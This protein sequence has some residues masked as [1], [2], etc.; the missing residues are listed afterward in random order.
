MSKKEVVERLNN[1]RRTINR[2]RYLYHVLDQQEISEAALDSLKHELAELE[3]QYPDLVTPDSPT[4]RVGGEP[5][6]KFTK[7]KHPVPQWSFNDAFTPDEMRE[8][9]KRV[10]KAL[11]VDKKPT[12]IAELKIDGFKIVLTYV[13]GLLKTAATR[14]NGQVG[15]DVTA[16]V[17]TIEAIPLKLE[18]EVDVVVEGEIWLSK[19][20]FD[21]INKEQKNKGESLYANPRNVAAGTIRQLDPKVVSSRHLDNFIYDLAQADF[22]LPPTQQAELQLLAELGFK[23]NKYHIFCSTIEEV[24]AFWQEWQVKKDKEAYWIDGVVVKVNEQNYQEELGYTGKAPRFAIAFKFPAEQA[25][26]VVEDIILQVGRQGTITPVARLRPTFLAGST[27]SRATLHNE[28][29]IKRLDVR[30]GDTVILQKA[31]DV[32]PDIVQVMTEMRTGQEKIFCWPKKLEACLPIGAGEKEKSGPI[33]RI[34]GQAAWRCVNK[35][36]FAQLRRKFYHFVSKAAFDIEKL[37]PRVVDTLLENNLVARYDDI[38][39]IKKG[40]LLVLPRFAEKS[41]D[42]LIKAI[43]QRRK[44]SLSRF[45][46]SLSIPGVGVETAEEVAKHF[47]DLGKL[48]QADLEKL[49]A[50]AGVGEIIGQSIYDW[51]HDKENQTIIRGLLKEV[52]VLPFKKTIDSKKLVKLKFVLTGTL[53]TLSR[54]EAKAIIKQNGGEISGSVSAQTDYVLAGVE[55][56]AKLDKAHELGVRVID[57]QEFRQLL[58]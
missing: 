4:Q 8:F 39:R 11:G 22:A 19:N 33:E 7:V 58:K 46:V 28:D 12:Y 47:G 51:F 34:P 15:E 43:D 16:N 31:G 50:I 20:N 9:D 21:Q 2:H 36:S 38:F 30:I 1:L 3:A 5:L 6:D 25:T 45:I 27:V 52:K 56:G 32:I 23:V 13:N 26:T 41:V 42:N 57:E 10:K 18:Q 40:D 14:G 24:I 54:E 37:G 48:Q 17:K 35:N 53:P 29:E 55:A 44:I 49:Q